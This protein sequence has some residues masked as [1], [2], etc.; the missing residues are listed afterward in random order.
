[1]AK[2]QRILQASLS[3]AGREGDDNDESHSLHSSNSK[4]S[5]SKIE[6]SKLEIARENWKQSWYT[7]FDWIEFS[8]EEGRVFCKICKKHGGRNVFAKA[9]SIHVKVSAFQDHGKSEEHK[10]YVWV[11]QKGKKT[12]EKMVAA[13]NKACD[14]VVLSFFK[15][16]YFLGKETISFCKF[17]SLCEMLVS[18]NG[19]IT[20]KLYHDEKACAKLYFCVSKVLQKSYL[21]LCLML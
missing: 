18:L 14:E 21:M 1:M 13:S 12:I 7:M 9:G 10:N 15:A 17:P 4:G 11:D 3:R 20:T 6:K 16:A 2:R 5:T 19:N 8:Y